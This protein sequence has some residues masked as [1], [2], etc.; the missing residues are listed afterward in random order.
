M[1]TPIRRFFFLAELTRQRHGDQWLADL[2]KGSSTPHFPQAVNA[3]SLA[4]KAN[5]TG[6][7]DVSRQHAHSAE[8]MFSATGNTA[9]VLR[10]RFE[11]IFA[12]Q[13]ERHSQECRREATFAL[14]DSEKHSYPWLE[15]QLGLEKAA[16]SFVNNDIGGDE[17]AS[18]RAMGRAQNERYQSLYLRAVHFAADD[19]L[20]TGDQHGA[21][22]LASAGLTQFWSERIPYL[23]GYSLYVGLAEAADAANQPHLQVAIWREAVSLVSG[24]DDLLQRAMAHSGL[25]HAAT[26]AGLSRIAQRE[27]AEAA[28]LFAIAP[29]SAA[30]EADAIE[31]EIHSSR[32]EGRL[33]HFDEAIARL[34]AVQDQVRTLSTNYL[35]QIFYS[36]LGELQLGRHREREAE[37]ALRPAL[38]FAEQNLASLRSEQERI[39]WSSTAAP[40][41]LAL[42][43]AELLQGRPQEA[44]ETYEWYLGAPQ[45][46]E[47]R[48]A[49]NSPAPGPVPLASRLPLLT[50]ETVLSYAVLP[51]GLAIWLFDDRGVN[52]RWI[53]GPVEGLQE[54]AARFQDLSS[55]P[56]SE[57]S[58][59]RR[60]A[61]SLYDELVRPMEQQL[62][63]ERTLVIEADGTL[64][65][66][67]FEALLDSNNHYLIER[68]PIVHSLGLNAQS[69]LRSATGISSDL[70]ALVVGSTASSAADG[71]IPLP[72]VSAEADAVAA[73][74]RFKHV[75]KGREATLSSVRSELPL[76]SIFH[77]AG[78]SLDAR[79]GSGLLLENSDEGVNTLH[80]MD[81][82]VVRQLRL[83]NL[84]L[85]VL[86]ACSTG[87]SRSGSSGFDNFADALLRAGVPHVIASRWAVDSAVTRGFVQDFYANA[88]SGQ[89]VSEAIRRTSQKMLSNPGTAHPYYWAAF[90]AYGRP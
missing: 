72:D 30:S 21:M 50:K 85:A 23:R 12:S 20:S 80:L 13:M 26:D 54:L 32:L 38:A 59:V 55:D 9:G 31:T 88:L 82:S 86:S 33:G 56:T 28:R 29:R 17:R 2:L 45:R 74:F 22:S 15:I 71:L 19:K 61:R 37:Q 44:L 3:L 40:A 70:H 64:A 53:P 66:L 1:P 34:I 46:A 77:F 87:L 68:A 39:S 47:L 83:Q 43:E 79:Q 7:Y 62:A 14:A 60:D 81:S 35:P 27:Y 57:P 76:A 75:L 25:A 52:S 11:S 4:A 10:A 78:H 16:C 51:D 24:D 90:A 8:Q 73:G 84:Q 58:A 89:T 69:R 6:N 65:S 63:P 49:S 41:Y 42:I 18:A 48:P 67:P 36:T 5:D